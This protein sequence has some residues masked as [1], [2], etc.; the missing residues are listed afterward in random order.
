MY[1]NQA[2]FISY[3]HL[4]FFFQGT[5]EEVEKFLPIKIERI[6][7][8][9]NECEAGAEAV[10]EKFDHTM[11][12]IEELLRASLAKQGESEQLQ[13]EIEVNCSIVFC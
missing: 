11:A 4:Y 12:I 10:V 6:T 1:H 7:E 2:F 8:I 9:A 3:L 5:D 13:R